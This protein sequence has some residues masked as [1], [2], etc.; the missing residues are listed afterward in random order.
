[1]VVACLMPVFQYE[2]IM[3]LEPV[4]TSAASRG[5][6]KLFKCNCCKSSFAKPTNPGWG[7]LKG[8]FFWFL[9]LVLLALF[10]PGGALYRQ[11]ELFHPVV[12]GL[13]LFLLF[14]SLVLGVAFV[15]SSVLSSPKC[16][17]CGSHNFAKPD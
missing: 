6:S 10:A 5:T 15:F 14:G 11:H 8:L 4:R 12:T 3:A 2:S 17:D 13:I 16:P 1:L 9:A 7:F